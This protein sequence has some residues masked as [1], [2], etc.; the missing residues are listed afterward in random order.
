MPLLFALTEIKAFLAYTSGLHVIYMYAATI[1]DRIVTAAA[2]FYNITYGLAALTMFAALLNFR[3]ASIKYLTDL[4]IY[5]H[6]PTK[7]F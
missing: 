6:L 7:V 1:I 3:R 5:S 2:T 4:Q